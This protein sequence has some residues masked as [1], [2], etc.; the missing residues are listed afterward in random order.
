MSNFKSVEDHEEH[1]IHTR[2]PSLNVETK[3][4]SSY[5][6]QELDEIEPAIHYPTGPPWHVA[7]TVIEYEVEI[8]FDI[9]DSVTLGRSYPRLNLYE[10]IDL[11]PFNAYEL[12]VSR[13]HATLI[14][15]SGQ[16]VIQDH[17]SNNG[18]LVN[19]KKLKPNSNYLL[20]NGVTLHLGRM[21]LRFE[22]LYN[23]FEQ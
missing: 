10:G 12:G 5:D 15:V 16:V 14:L 13:H 20:E 21:A 23:P 2:P 22:M 18:T 7:L 4:L 11:S 3:N 9:T 19:N 8:V 17:N 1:T 6:I